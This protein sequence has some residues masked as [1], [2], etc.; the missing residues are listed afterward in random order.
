MRS[1][2]QGV[3][4]PPLQVASLLAL[5]G[6]AA[7]VLAAGHRRAGRGPQ[8][9]AAAS[10][11]QVQDVIVTSAQRVQSVLGQDAAVGGRHRP[12]RDRD[13][14]ASAQL[15]PILVGVVP[16]VTVP[17]GFSNQPQ[18]VGIRGVGVSVPAMSQ[19][20]GIYVDDVPIVRGYA[21][22]L[23]DLPDITR[24]EVLRGPAGHVAV[25]PEHDR[26]RG[27]RDLDRSR[28]REPVAWVSAS[29]GNYRDARGGMPTST[30]PDRRRAALGQPGPLAARQRGLRLQRL[31][32][33]T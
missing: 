25:R 2:A 3:A 14:A 23:W 13:L 7:P 26:W 18:A 20:V 22:A 30:W 19:A 8:A 10:T 11:P 32:R 31:H 24:I 16:G 33:A 29:T 17:N 15:S 21:T 5:A 6:A 28:R 9:S 27:A 4:R 12:A 1:K